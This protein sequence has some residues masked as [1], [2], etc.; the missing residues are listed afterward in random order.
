MRKN[1]GFGLVERHLQTGPHPELNIPDRLP[2]LLQLH[3]DIHE[4]VRH[5]R[6]GNPM[7]RVK[8]CGPMSLSKEVE[9]EWRYGLFLPRFR[10]IVA[11]LITQVVV[12]RRVRETMILGWYRSFGEATFM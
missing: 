9:A 8:C 5:N 7:A 2:Y 10:C 6:I 11:L 12:P 4:R 1:G 3:L